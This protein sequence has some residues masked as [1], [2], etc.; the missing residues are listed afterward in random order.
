MTLPSH[1]LFSTLTPGSPFR[2]YTLLEQIGVGGQGVVWS[3]LDTKKNRINAIKFNEVPETD[4]AQAEDVRDE[5]QFH[6][7]VTLHHAHVLPIQEFG[8]EGTMRFSVSP[9][10]PGGTVSQKVKSA[11]LTSRDALRYSME[12]AS[13]L[14]F[15]HSQ[16]VIHRDLKA[17]NVLLDLGDTT[18]LA[19]F[20]LARII[21]T[22]TLAFHTGH[23]TPP[24]APPEQNRLKE[25]T[26]KSDIYSFG[27][28]LYEMFTGQLPW[29]G[30]KQLGMEQLHSDQEIPDPCE[31]NPD[32][33]SRM[34]DVLR[35]VTAA[36]PDMR[37][38]SA[39][40]VMKMVYYIFGIPYEPL[41]SPEPQDEHA[42]QK[43]DVDELL[44][45][46]LAQWKATE[47]TY[48]LGLT[49]FALIDLERANI[50]VEMFGN[51]LLSQSLT[52]GYKDD[53]WWPAVDDPRERL[54]VSSFL[55][56][57]DNE[58]IAAR[59][60]EQ[61]TGDM[62]IRAFSNGVPGAI[63]NSLLEIG[64]KSTDE[65]FRQ[66]V[67]QSLRELTRPGERWDEKTASLG[68]NHLQYLGELA[69]EDS[70]AGDAAA[71][72]I[73]HLRSTSAVRVVTDYHDE[74][75]KVAA[76]LLIQ[77]TA[78][79]LPAYVH[80][81]L[82]FRLKLEWAIQRL[83]QQPVRLVSVYVLAFLGSSL[84]VGLQNYFT[85]NFTGIFNTE[86]ITLSLERGLIIG[87][88]FGLGIFVSRVLV[89]RFH[90]SRAM[91]RILLGTLTGGVGINLALLV[92]HVLFLNTPPR[93]MLIT[94]GSLLI[95]FAF[96]V[97]GFIRSYLVKV[98]LSSASVLAVI[99]GTWWVY[100]N[101]AGSNLD[102]TPIFKYNDA[103]TLAQVSLTALMVALPIG[104]LGSMINLKIIEDET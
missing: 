83:T 81:R 22:S 20:G 35:R 25:I 68:S 82:R 4:E 29:N 21:S 74:D 71:E 17:S 63:T 46:G 16:G 72:L 41:S 53:Q 62:E 79:N 40:D 102:M 23:G 59:V 80:G 95:A 98:L 100:V 38:R 5:F 3:A 78:G 43:R 90:T 24:Y 60:L 93:G 51:F 50:N 104:I 39:G 19:D 66:Q 15:L 88:V 94:A 89:E 28:L 32:L 73:G 56:R 34:V 37:P 2:Q 97:G 36:D 67:F 69:L 65:K 7:L 84:G 64:T 13:A 26:P 44:W 99:A 42:L 58:T 85:I 1:L 49:R 45:Q 87:S 12:I 52:Y 54:S 10:I 86:R 33:P 101:Y 61:L 70:E 11:P 6:K 30:K 9:Y 92:F 48:N 47:G 91:P 55:L 103:W 14:D 75:R 77:Q 18:Y 76:L 27:I 96:V 57:K 8:F 31:I